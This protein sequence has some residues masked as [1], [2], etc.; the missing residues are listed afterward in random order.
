MVCRGATSLQ[1]GCGAER[2]SASVEGIEA[3][4]CI[5]RVARTNKHSPMR[6]QS[7]RLGTW[8]IT[9]ETTM[10]NSSLQQPGPDTVVRRY[11]P[12]WQLEDLVQ[13]S[14]LYCRRLDRFPD[15]QDGMPDVASGQSHADPWLKGVRQAVD[16]QIWV[17]SWTRI[18]SPA[19]AQWQHFTPDDEQQ[20]VAL[21]TTARALSLSIRDP[22]PWQL[23]NVRYLAVGQM[24]A[25]RD[26][27]TLA[28]SRQDAWAGEREVRLLSH[29]DR[30]SSRGDNTGNRRLQVSLSAM[31]EQIEISPLA[32][33]GLNGRVRQVLATAGLS[34]VPVWQSRYLQPVG[35]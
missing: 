25:D 16:D 32:E 13:S 11:M 14:E 21:L 28:S 31:I 8:F 35:C 23:V 1:A 3:D 12:L 33:A 6:G 19:I 18:E 26:A 34:D 24:P 5:A 15:L 20:G 7:G 4:V 10:A 17:S 22:R 9:S 2:L 29:A 27:L 30:Y